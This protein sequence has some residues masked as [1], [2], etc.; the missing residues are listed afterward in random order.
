[1]I[2]FVCGEQQTAGGQLLKLENGS[3]KETDAQQ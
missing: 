1:M 2:H 3:I